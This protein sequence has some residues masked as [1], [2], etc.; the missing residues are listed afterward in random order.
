MADKLVRVSEKA[1][2]WITKNSKKMSSKMFVDLIVEK[3]E[4]T[5]QTDYNFDV[6]LKGSD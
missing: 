1:H 5:N 6:Q 4:I 2:K 3:V